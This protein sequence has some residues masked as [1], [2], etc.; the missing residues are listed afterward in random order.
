MIYERKP[1]GVSTGHSIR[2]LTCG[3]WRARY[4]LR[5]SLGVID[6]KDRDAL[7]SRSG[8]ILKFILEPGIRFSLQTW[9]SFSGLAMMRI[10]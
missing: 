2:S 4:L 5:Y 9:V 6:G 1:A 8:I 7:Y 3:K 10:A